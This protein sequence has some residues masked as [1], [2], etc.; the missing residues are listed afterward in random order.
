MNFLDFHQIVADHSMNNTETFFTC[1]I[2]SLALKR[3]ANTN[4]K[5]PYGGIVKL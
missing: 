3:I 4:D 2:S 1:I 5:N